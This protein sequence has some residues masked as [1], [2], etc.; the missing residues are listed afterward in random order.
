MCL[1]WKNWLKKTTENLSDVEDSALIRA[2]DLIER[3]VQTLQAYR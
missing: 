1:D 2:V 3:P